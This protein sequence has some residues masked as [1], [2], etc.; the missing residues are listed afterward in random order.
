MWN[1]KNDCYYTKSICKNGILD[2]IKH[3]IRDNLWWEITYSDEYIDK[4]IE[5]DEDDIDVNNIEEVL[6]YADN[7]LSELIEDVLN[8]YNK[9]NISEI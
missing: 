2:C 3:N 7:W 6:E 4:Y 1:K 8:K 5:I 9:L